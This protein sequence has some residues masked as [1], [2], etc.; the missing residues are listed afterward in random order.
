MRKNQ[1]YPILKKGKIQEEH[2]KPIFVTNR[3]ENLYQ[4]FKLR[5]KLKIKLVRKNQDY[6]QVK[7][8]KSLKFNIYYQLNE[9]E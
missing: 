3:Q 8:G 5:K 2:L 4:S 9:K 6:A 1:D 7:K